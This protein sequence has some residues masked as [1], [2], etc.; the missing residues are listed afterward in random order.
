[1]TTRSG[2][3]IKHEPVGSPSGSTRSGTMPP[4]SPSPKKRKILHDEYVTGHVGTAS[5]ATQSIA[6]FARSLAP[7]AETHQRRDD[8]QEPMFLEM[9]M[10]PENR[11]GRH[12][13][14]SS[15][16]ADASFAQQSFAH[17]TFTDIGMKQKACNDTLGD[18][19]TLG[20]S[21][22]AA[23]PELVL[24]G[25][26]SSG[27]SSLMSGLARVN[28]PRSAGVCTRCPL[29][30]RL[31]S[32]HNDRWSCTVSLQQDF[33]FQPLPDRKPKTSDVTRAN[34]FPPWV[35]RSH[36]EIKPF[37]TIYEP[38]EIEEVLRWAQVA[39]LN[40]NQSFERFIPGEGA[41]AKEIP[42]DT[43]ARQ[44]DAQFSPNIVA[45]EIKGPGLPDLSFYDLPGVFISPEKEEDGYVVKVVKNLTLE[46]IGREKAI[47]IWA[48][49]M[50]VDSENSISLDIIR[51]SGAADRTIG[52]M[53]KADQLP[54]QNM[55]NWLAMFRGEKQ[56]VGHGFF[57]T[58]RP[59]DQQLE[60][61]ARWEELFFNRDISIP[62]DWPLEFKEFSDRCGVEVLLKY[63]SRQLGEAFARSLP[64]IKG[65]VDR[66]LQ[67][68]EGELDALP[69]LPHN[70][71]HEVKRSLMQFLQQMKTAIRGAD[72]CSRWNLLNSQL[73]DCVEKMKP[74]CTVKDSDTQTI[75]I[76]GGDS[77][78][79]TPAPRRPRPS[80]STMRNV[81]TPSKRQRQDPFTT[82]V[83]QEDVMTGPTSRAS[84][85]FGAAGA[86]SGQNPFTVFFN[87]GRGAMDIKTIRADI[88]RY[89][90][91]GQSQHHV[92]DEVRDGLC[93][94]AIEK[95]SSP[96]DV[97][98]KKT[99]EL[100]EDTARTAL[101][102]SLGGL[103]QRLIFRECQHHLRQFIASQVARQQARLADMYNTETYE[104]FVLNNKILDAR[105][106]EELEPLN[107]IRGIVR[108]KALTLIDWNYPT[109]QLENMTEEEKIKERKMLDANLPKLPKDPYEAEIK[110][111][112]FVRGYYMMAARRFAEG[113]AIN[114]NSTLLRTFRE[115]E[116][117]VYMDNEFHI[118]GHAD[119]SLYT[120]LMEEDDKTAK[121]RLQL[122]AEMEKLVR[123]MDSIRKLEDSSND[124]IVKRPYVTIDSDSEMGECV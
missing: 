38:S 6:P 114:V 64:S 43:A 30:I 57:A 18:L 60:E 86:D 81:A 65:M 47:I 71:E 14:P 37:K 92:P 53:T 88:L 23:L 1:M 26:Q 82:P 104:T 56:S 102:E 85:V 100:L 49:P 46:Y 115:S 51:R 29:H 117:D 113:V 97:Y 68:I 35:K 58:A 70:V 9:R 76:S 109:K 16:N 41:V 108:L 8:D 59:P 52:V 99:A 11:V 94:R 123:A 107:R 15:Q 54:P 5:M 89:K 72:F 79:T 106:A 20:V 101:D 112:G 4:P 80:D 121:R 105:E 7:S 39:I 31:I 24:V 120:K 83:K 118:Y 62:N 74:K 61:A 69:E 3:P 44:T 19:Q 45:L 36:R 78:A 42:L 124:P 98:I 21:H 84:S 103:R 95:W 122:K 111:A 75:D 48:F 93:L 77:G 28:L 50:N 27:K 91:P 22:V 116:L 33:D 13:T 66:R 10:R 55:P 25:D 119:P 34:P 12:S 63:L 67:L 73:L 40:H 32:S 87:L 96:L 2:R 90:R 17:P 110:V